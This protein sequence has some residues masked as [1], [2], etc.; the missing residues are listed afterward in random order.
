LRSRKRKSRCGPTARTQQG[1]H[2]FTQPLRRHDEA[3]RQ[4]RR[5]PLGETVHDN[6]GVRRE[7]GKLRLMVEEAI[8]IVLD[9]RK[10]EL[11]DDAQK[12]GSPR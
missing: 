10:I 7:R 12:I 1:H 2:A 9:D 11:F 8:D 3:Q 6:A 5:D 4:A